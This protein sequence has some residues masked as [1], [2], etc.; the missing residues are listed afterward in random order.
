MSIGE[1]LRRLRDDFPDISIS[2]IRFLEAEGLIDPER[3]ASGYRKFNSADL[4][5]LRYILAAQR[6]RYL[7]LK[8]I[9]EHL[10]AMA[11]GLEP[12]ASAGEVPR[13][14]VAATSAVEQPMAAA[15]AMRLSREELLANSGLSEAQLGEL[16]SYGLVRPRAGGTEYDAAALAIA[17][18]AAAMASHG[19]EPRHL[20]A[21][22]TA[23][24]REA[25]LIEQF[26][27]PVAR[28]REEDAAER[29]AD[30]RGELAALAA[31]LHSALLRQG[32]DGS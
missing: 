4:E 19:L 24:D 5:R 20:R 3:T 28:S 22:K 32:L 29:A 11:R 10:D 15:P 13:A 25:G 16:D 12:P 9:R 30:L 23:A 17:T 7:P 1:V 27:A 31:R 14:P 8:V 6:D 2:K 18:V 21:F 26:A